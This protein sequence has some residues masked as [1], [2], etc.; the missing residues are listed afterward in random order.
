[1]KCLNHTLLPP[2]LS[3]RLVSIEVQIGR[4]AALLRTCARI[5]LLEV[6]AADIR[7]GLGTHAPGVTRG[8]AFLTVSAWSYAPLAAVWEPVMEPWQVLGH[9]DLNS[10]SR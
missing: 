9:V 4:C 6:G 10:T 7:V 3:H 8:F 2:L 5:P 1:M